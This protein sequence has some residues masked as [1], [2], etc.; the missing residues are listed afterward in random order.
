MSCFDGKF[1]I[2]HRLIM[3]DHLCGPL[4]VLF[5]SK[6]NLSWNNARHLNTAFSTVPDFNQRQ[7]YILSLWKWTSVYLY[8]YEWFPFLHHVSCIL[9]RRGVILCV[10]SRLFE[11]SGWF[12][13]TFS[14]R[15]LEVIFVV[16]YSF[17]WIQMYT[18]LFLN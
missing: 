7:Y 15:I 11:R 16:N 9:Y 13:V 10:S 8:K 2:N 5:Q 3:A 4:F 12:G 6:I 1:S 18:F 14:V 17:I